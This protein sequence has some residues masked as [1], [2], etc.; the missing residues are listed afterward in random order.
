VGGPKCI[1]LAVGCGNGYTEGEDFFEFDT[2]MFGCLGNP[3]KKGET[4]LRVVARG[5]FQAGLGGCADAVWRREWMVVANV[6][7]PLNLGAALMG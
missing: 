2:G 5:L 1:F 3:G 6:P 7:G 4:L